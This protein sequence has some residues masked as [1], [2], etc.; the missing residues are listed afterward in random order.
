MR[1]IFETIKRPAVW[2]DARRFSGDLPFG[3]PS[4]RKEIK[5]CV[6]KDGAIAV[7]IGPNDRMSVFVRLAQPHAFTTFKETA[8]RPLFLS[9]LLSAVYSLV[10]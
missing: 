7:D 2:P 3:K 6:K 10:A 5:G 4:I 9:E 8:D 1:Q